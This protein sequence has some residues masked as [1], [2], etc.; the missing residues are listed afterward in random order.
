IWGG[1]ALRQWAVF[2]LGR[3]FT[4]VVRVSGTQ[5]AI[6]RGPFRWVRHPSYTGLLLTLAGLGMAIG[7]WL[8]LASLIVLP[9][10]GLAFRIRVE[11]AVL[12]STLKGYREYAEGRPRLIPW[13]W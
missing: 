11:E 12:M 3:Y 9:S 6:D 8:S 7:N 10:I 4:V 2:T 1:I 5:R 13:V